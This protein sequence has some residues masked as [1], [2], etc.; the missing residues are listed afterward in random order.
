MVPGCRRKLSPFC[1]EENLN[2]LKLPRQGLHN[3]T[4]QT[5]DDSILNAKGIQGHQLLQRWV[6]FNSRH[7]DLF[8]A[9][10]I[11]DL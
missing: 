7:R 3:H 1:D 4:A 11:E 10:R 8:K 9:E 2:P 6:W 5:H